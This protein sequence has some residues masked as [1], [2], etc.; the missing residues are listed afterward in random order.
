MVPPQLIRRDRRNQHREIGFICVVSIYGALRRTPCEECA[1]GSLPDCAHQGVLIVS[2]RG[3]HEDEI[4][5]NDA[6]IL[7]CLLGGLTTRYG[8][9]VMATHADPGFGSYGTPPVCHEHILA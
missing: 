5:L 1:S 3:E 4:W 2:D 7:Q 6:R 8:G 9:I